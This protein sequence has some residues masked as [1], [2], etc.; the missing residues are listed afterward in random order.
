MVAVAPNRA[1]TSNEDT[2]S[3][4]GE[5]YQEV[6]AAVNTTESRENNERVGDIGP[7]DESANPSIGFWQ[8]LCTRGVIMWG[9]C[10]F[11]IKFAVYSLLLWMPLFLDQELGYD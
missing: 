10:F 7:M 4:S 11:C 3:A 6:G 1:A 2:P 8:A 5:G 9:L